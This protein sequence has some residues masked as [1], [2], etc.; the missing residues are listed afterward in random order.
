MD[1]GQG[2]TLLLDESRTNESA[3][4]RE[5]DPRGKVILGTLL[6]P[7]LCGTNRNYKDSEWTLDRY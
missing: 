1:M 4:A 6:S 5:I 7:K 2:F 3:G